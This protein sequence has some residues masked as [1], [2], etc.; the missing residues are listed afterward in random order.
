MA[1]TV[2]AWVLRVVSVLLIAYAVRA[3][4]Y[5]LTIKPLVWKG[6]EVVQPPRTRL[7]QGAGFLTAAILVW[8][9]AGLLQ[10]NMQP[11]YTTW[12]GAGG[13]CAVVAVL[14]RRDVK[15]RWPLRSPGDVT[16]VEVVSWTLF[17]IGLIGAAQVSERVADGF[18][19]DLVWSGVLLGVFGGGTA[20]AWAVA[21]LW[22]MSRP[23]PTP[24]P[25]DGG[26]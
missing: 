9:L 14:L 24:G 26:R 21:R 12:I 18:R 23:S 10:G 19:R 13:A 25:K 15:R 7:L 2:L 17:V 11:D 8:L 3:F 22:M 1:V 16:A 4:F 20:I 5:G 6:T